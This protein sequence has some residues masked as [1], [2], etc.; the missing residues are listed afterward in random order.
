MNLKVQPVYPN[1][2]KF[3]GS[4]SIRLF[5][6]VFKVILTS[7]KGVPNA[8]PQCRKTISHY[9]NIEDSYDSFKFLTY[10]SSGG[11]G[12]QCVKINLK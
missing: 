4:D 11:V 12:L 9:L 3:C 1:K 8:N 2:T 10:Y 7:P 5:V 6:L